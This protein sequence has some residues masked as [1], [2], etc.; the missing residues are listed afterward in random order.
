MNKSKILVIAVI[1]LAILNIGLLIFVLLG[2]PPKHGPHNKDRNPKRLDEMAKQVLK[3]DDTQIALFSES[4]E[5][6][7]AKISPLREELDEISNAYYNSSPNDSILRDSLL[8]TID[9]LNE[10]VYLANLIHF[11]DLRSIGRDDQ[12]AEIDEFIKRLING[13]SPHKR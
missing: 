5:I 6:H 4:R 12:Q 9:S 13:R 2:A 7:G 1:L 8:L 11:D 3:F 10:E